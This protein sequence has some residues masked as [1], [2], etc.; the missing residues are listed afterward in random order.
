MASPET[1]IRN[2]LAQSRENTARAIILAHAAALDTAHA[3]ELGDKARRKRWYRCAIPLLERAASALADPVSA[4]SAL[5]D[6]RIAL[7]D[8]QG[9]QR[10]A[11]RVLARD[12]KHRR[13]LRQSAFALRQLGRDGEALDLLRHYTSIASGWSEPWCEMTRLHA[14]RGNWPQTVVSAREALRRDET[15]LEIADLLIDGLVASRRESEAEEPLRTLARSNP[16]KVQ[17]DLRMYLRMERPLAAVHA[18]RA[19]IAARGESAEVVET[20]VQLRSALMSMKERSISDAAEALALLDAPIEAIRLQPQ[21]RGL[22][23]RIMANFGG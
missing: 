2:A 21:R 6:C 8:W 15:D 18:G 17:R 19:L 1:E 5:V 9:A 20:M 11:E 13:V 12:P 4:G 23:G 22:I 3:F 7:R 10:D 14:L 16:Y